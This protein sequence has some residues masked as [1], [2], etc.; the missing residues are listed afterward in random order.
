[1]DIDVLNAILHYLRKRGANI[2]IEIKKLT[3]NKESI[4]IIIDSTNTLREDA[5]DLIHQDYSEEELAGMDEDEIE[6]LI[7][8]YVEELEEERK[9]DDDDE[10]YRSTLG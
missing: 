7:E 3:D 1:M 6:D 5:L 2:S 4:E 8:E 9:D 10:A